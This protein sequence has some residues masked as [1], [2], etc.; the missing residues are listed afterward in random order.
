[1]RT[2]TIAK[3]VMLELFRDK[4]TLALMF[5]APLL[6][7]WLL[8]VMFSVNS[9]V[10]VKLA[11]VDVNQTV[12]KNMQKV[13][14]VSIKQYS[15]KKDAKEALKDDKIDGVIVQRDNKYTVTY[16]NTDSSK[17]TLTKQT[18][19]TWNGFGYGKQDSSGI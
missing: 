16:A 9:D 3:R 19:R 13:D 17:T 7:L 14:G 2:W 15:S 1:M 11:T 6:I 4:R 12:I 18:K 5:I 8:S 10:N